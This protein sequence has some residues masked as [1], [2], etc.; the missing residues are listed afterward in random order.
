MSAT[1]VIDRIETR[2]VHAESR[3]W[4]FVLVRTS[5][6]LTGLGEATLEWKTR[7][8]TGCVEDLSPLLLGRDASDPVALWDEIV[9]RG[10]YPLGS[11]VATALSGIDQALWDMAGKRSG[12]PVWRLLEPSAARASLP[13][14]INLPNGESSANGYVPDAS[15]I[16]AAIA[17]AREAGFR[18]VKWKPVAPG[19]SGRE[20]GA[21]RALV[22]ETLATGTSVALDVHGRMT[23]DSARALVR[24][25]PEGG[26]ERF[27]FLEEPCRPE[28]QA[29]WRALRRATRLPLATGE[30]LSSRFPFREIVREGV[31]D[32]L[33]PDVCRIGGITEAA[34]LAREFPARAIAPHCP[35]GPVALAASV[36][37]G[38]AFGNVM[39]QEVFVR[40]APWR[41]GV[42]AGAP[43]PS[44]G[45]FAPPTAPGLGVTLD[46][47]AAAAHPFAEVAPP[48]PTDP[49]GRP[50]P[51]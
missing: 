11:V 35:L 6:G 34:R 31:A 42:I 18:A 29:G 23:G 20:S 14:Y 22:E 28:D 8:V 45:V 49:E 36:Q 24:E 26:W 7:A 19:S 17:A 2:V 47:R 12:V 27:L 3:N 9:L 40:D 5:D 1:S 38:F 30:R 51:W 15:P 46:E 10:Y 13:A 16:R 44:A 50:L 43:R 37:L 33:Q 4:V 41:D 32:V 48:R 25:W 39:T 21:V